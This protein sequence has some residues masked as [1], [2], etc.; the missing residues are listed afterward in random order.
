MPMA[1]VDPMPVAPV[2]P[3]HKRSFQLGSNIM[4]VW[5]GITYANNSLLVALRVGRRKI[6][7]HLK[8]EDQP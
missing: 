3:A 2:R 8:Q 4:Q 6:G 1:P 7:G 5:Y